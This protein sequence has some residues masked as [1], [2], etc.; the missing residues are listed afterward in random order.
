MLIIIAAH[1][2]IFTLQRHEGR[3]FAPMAYSVVSALIASLV[4]SL[5]LVPLLSYW[6]LRGKLSRMASRACLVFS[7]RLYAPALRWA[8]SH[9]AGAAAG[10]AGLVIA[11]GAATRLGSEFL[12]ELNEGSVWLNVT[13]EPSVSISEAQ[14]QASRIPA[15]WC[16]RRRRSRVSSASWAAPRTAPTPRS[17]ARSR[18][19]STCMTITSGPGA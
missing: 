17:P 16:A 7:K 12:P 11:M 1:I 2:P 6:L 15:R 13:L 4:L 3:I 14:L 9:R 10:A 18:R 8:L 5:T 19:W